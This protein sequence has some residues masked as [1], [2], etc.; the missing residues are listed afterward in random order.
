MANVQMAGKRR[1]RGWPGALLVLACAF[2]QLPALAQAVSSEA[3]LPALAQAWL[4]RT[5]A[6]QAARDQLPVRLEATLGV[7]DSRLR[8]A[9]CARVEAYLPPG[10]RLWGSS[11]IGLRCLEGARRW[12]VSIPVT[13]KATGSAWVLRRD[14]APGQ[15]L[16]AGDLM[17]AEVDWTA[18]ASPVLAGRDAWAGQVATRA[19]SAGQTLRQNMVRAAQVFQ[20]GAQVRVLVQGGGFQISAL[21]QALSPGVVGQP[22]R[23]R[24]DSGRVLSAT[25]L[26]ARTVRVEL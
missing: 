13:V 17:L 25:V 20:A 26:D 6:A 5:L 1:T 2:I 23:V 8:L 14:V 12:N 19:L 21:A 22:A 16:E 10:S 9:P 4:D 18:E 11:R 7:L 24:T 3:Q 15:P